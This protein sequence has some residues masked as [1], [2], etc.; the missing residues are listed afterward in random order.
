VRFQVALVARVPNHVLVVYGLGST[1]K[2]QVMQQ[3][4]TVSKEH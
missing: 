2:C 3:P 1:Y 4:L